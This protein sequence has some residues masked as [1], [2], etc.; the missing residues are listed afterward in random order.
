MTK[1]EKKSTNTKFGHLDY[2]QVK[3]ETKLTI[4]F[5]HGLGINKEWFV[6]QYEPYTSRC[7]N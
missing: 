1:I 4:L 6:K 2:Y 5:I 7:R 3:N